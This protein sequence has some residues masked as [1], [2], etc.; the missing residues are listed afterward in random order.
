MAAASPPPMQIPAMPYFSPRCF[1]A[2]DV[3]AVCLTTVL[4][5]PGRVDRLHWPVCRLADTASPQRM[6]AAL[7][8]AR[9]YALFTLVG[10]AGEDRRA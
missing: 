2:M 5:T 3:L 7:S 8:Y 6:R 4:P 10:M 1:S 9:R